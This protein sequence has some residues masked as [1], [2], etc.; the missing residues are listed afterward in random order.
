M[1]TILIIIMVS[2][3]RFYNETPQYVVEY[4]TE[5]ECQTVAATYPDKGIEFQKALCVPKVQRPTK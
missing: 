3:G 1:K 4:P 2:N 5:K